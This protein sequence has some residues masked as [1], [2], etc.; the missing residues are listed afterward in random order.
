MSVRQSWDPT[1]GLLALEHG[2][3]LVGGTMGAD[4]Q[5]RELREVQHLRLSGEHAAS[6]GYWSR[7]GSVVGLVQFHMGRVAGPL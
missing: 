3:E 1:E 6:L 7:P 4:F 5:R 2:R